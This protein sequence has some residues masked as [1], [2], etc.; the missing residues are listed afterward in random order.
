MVTPLRG[1]V[2]FLDLGYGYGVHPYVIVSENRRNRSA[3]G[4]YLAVELTTTPLTPHR[5][6]LRELVELRNSRPIIGTAKC[7]DIHTL[8]DRDLELHRG[9]PGQIATADMSAVDA[10]LRHAL[11]L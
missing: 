3:K 9:Q 8:E 4:D 1:Q 5:E 7:G 10:G 6:H 2:F 11:G